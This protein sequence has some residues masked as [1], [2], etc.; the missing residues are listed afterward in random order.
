MNLFRKVVASITLAA[1][2]ITTG[3]TGTSAY[4]N[5]ELVAANGLA[6]AGVINDNSANPAG[7]NFASTILRNES[8]KIAVNLD[9]G[10]SMKKTC[11]DSFADVSAT[12]PN[13]WTCGYAEALLDAGKVSANTNF[14]PLSNLTKAEA[15]KMM[16]EA[17]GC[18]DVYTN[19]DKWQAETVAFA[20][21]NDIV[22]SFTDYNTPAT[23]AF[24]FTVAYNAMNSCPIAD[25]ECDETMAALGLCEVEVVDPA[26]PTEP[27]EP[28]KPSE[29]SNEGASISLSP[30]TPVDGNVAAN[31]PRTALLAFD[32]TAGEEDLTLDEIDLKYTGL[33][34]SKNVTDLSIYLVND[35]VSRWTDKTFDSENEK[36]LSFEKNTVIK[37][38]ETKTL[39]VT[40][41][42][43]WGNL[44]ETHQVTITRLSSK[45][46]DLS[47]T[48]LVWASLNPVSVTNKGELEFSNDTA[49]EKVVIWEEISLA[50]FTLEET[51]KK[52]AVIVKS[53]TFTVSGSVDWEDDIA[54]L[55]LLA[56]GKEIPV[57][58]M[59]NSDDEIIADLNYEIAADDKIDFELK[60]VV[61][62]SV[63]KTI[64]VVLASG[65]TAGHEI[66]DIYAIGADNKVAVSTKIDASRTP[67]IADSQTI[68]WSEINVSFDKSETDE[69]KPDSE[70]V[71]VGTLKIS[72]DVNDY[73][74]NKLKVTVKNTTSS[75]G[76][77]NIVTKLEL[78]WSDS[79]AEYVIGTTN[80]ASST[81]T[82][83]DYI[84][85]DI[86]LIDGEVVLPLTVNISDS[87]SNNWIDLE[88]D[89]KFTEIE[90]EEQDVKYSSTDEL[91][92]VL[93]SNSF[94]TKTI[95]VETAT[96]SITSTEVNTRKL[97]LGNGVDAVV[98]KGKINVGD[99][100]NVTIKDFKLTN[101]GSSFSGIL[102]SN[103]NPVATFKDI[104]DTATL[105]IGWQTFKWD[106]NSKDIKFSWINA[107]LKAGLDNVEVLATVVLK[108]NDKIKNN[109]TLSMILDTANLE[110]KDSAG[111]SLVSANVTTTQANNT[112]VFT[113]LLD[114]GTLT[115]K[116]K[117]D[118]NNDD[119]LENTVLAWTS[120][121]T[122]A[123]LDI[124][125]EYEDIKVKELA[126]TLS[127]TK[128]FSNTLTNVKLV[129]VANNSVIADGAVISYSSPN[130]IVTFKND[131]V[132]ADESN[133]MDVELVADLNK[134]TGKWGETSAEAGDLKVTSVTVANASD[135]KWVQS[136]DDITW[137]DLSL[138]A[139]SNL[140][141]ISIVPTILR[142]S[143]V[144]SLSNGSAKFK[145]RADSGDNTIGNW[146]D[147]PEVTLT[148]LTFAELS[149]TADSYKIYKEWEASVQIS[150]T[151]TGSSIVFSSFGTMDVKF[152][153][154]QTYVLVPTGTKDKTYSPVL[155]GD[156]AEY[157]VNTSPATNS[158][159]KLDSEISLGS[160][161]Y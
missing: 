86:D 90:D 123:E 125:A 6:A 17:A 14:N 151:S 32:V 2:V 26:D 114:K 74:V 53:I 19:A 148:K 20:A 98:Y 30:E 43:T 34:E 136:N 44:N 64:E 15:T 73:T 16:L 142:F 158:S 91:N 157:S 135:I 138:S 45:A 56:D 70:D 51:S 35:K 31:T 152:D 113:N 33:S 50:G 59:V 140:E 116:I 58:L 5:D 63:G 65:K 66:N 127:W 13:D 126:I 101:S 72:A 121:V 18:T 4:T 87:T 132:I 118:V 124:E 95:S 49:S 161:T 85:K 25:V 155:S 12:T 48:P 111:D 89:V 150:P 109:D 75:I 104:I 88:F 36:E 97:V 145:I 137:G 80:N 144:Q 37:A 83:V 46:W 84:F 3:A 61:T 153:N 69:A 22:S 67:D 141:M 57:D 149:G 105:N 21:E 107:E 82:W 106:I 128:N 115:I 122:L 100:D 55:K 160:K 68:E 108:N 94:D 133:S 47:W 117:S 38:G 28:T 79:D 92:S 1:L 71:L 110:L 139:D 23:R 102:L 143:L 40:S 81:S 7:Y 39:V 11:D 147:K 60:G 146:D 103:A 154:E 156:V 134:I 54:D 27:T 8:A 77:T 62:G 24:V 99:A 41:Y 9:S 159:T 130:T 96:F 29:P 131:F 112:Q 129:N 42:L 10:V 93:S 78:W 76:V 52:E 119:N 120:S